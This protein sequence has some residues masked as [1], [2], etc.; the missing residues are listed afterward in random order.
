MNHYPADSDP[1]WTGRGPDPVLG[2]LTRAPYRIVTPAG[3][4]SPFVFACPHAGR[5]YPESFL[6]GSLLQL[7]ALRRSEDAFTDELFDGAAVHAPMLCARFPRAFLDVNRS[8]KELDPTM[9]EGRLEMETEASARVAAGFGVI[10]RIVREGAE[11]AR[12]KLA[13]WQAEERLALL[14]RPYHTALSRLIED[15]RAC[16]GF[17][18]VV[19]CHSMPG[20]P[21]LADIVLGDRFG[22]SASPGLIRLAERS[23]AA[24]GFS[25]AR[26]TPYAGGYTI[27]CHAKPHEGIHA[28]QIEVN[29]ALYLDEERIER[30]RHFDNVRKRIGEALTCIVTSDLDAI[31]RPGNRSP[32]AAE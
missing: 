11:I 9:F 14:H 13:P 19:D 2:E 23:F 31:C 26:N 4:A 17:A 18:V 6:A 8:P 25:V 28:F 15:A 10:P 29:R 7:P 5:L 24:Q 12:R 32:Q 16:F 22:A 30:G 20:A 1:E 21:K 3:K 27:A